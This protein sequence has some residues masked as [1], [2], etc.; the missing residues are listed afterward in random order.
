MGADLAIIAC[1]IEHDKD[2]AKQKLRTTYTPEQLLKMLANECCVEF[3][4]GEE[5]DYAE[6]L[7]WVDQCIDEVYEYYEHGSRE[8]TCFWYKDT[9]I[10]ITGGMTWGDDPTDAFQTMSVVAVLRLTEKETTYA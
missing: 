4:T 7:Q 2:T 3:R 5:E 8:T 1:P 10:L 9:P 6:A